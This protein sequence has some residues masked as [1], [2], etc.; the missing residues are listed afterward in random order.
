MFGLRRD[1][2]LGFLLQAG[3]GRALQQRW[4]GRRRGIDAAQWP[5]QRAAEVDESVQRLQQFMSAREL[6]LASE[7]GDGR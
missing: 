5:W 2:A 7:F 3:A 4:H 6:L 1:Q